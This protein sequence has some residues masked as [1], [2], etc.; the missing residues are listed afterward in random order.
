MFRMVPRKAL[1]VK[2]NDKLR[3]CPTCFKLLRNRFPYK[4]RYCSECGQKL[5]Y[6]NKKKK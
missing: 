1:K 3:R 2:Y 5:K 6:D 4:Q